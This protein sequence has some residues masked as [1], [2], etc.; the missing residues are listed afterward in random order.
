MEGTNKRVLEIF[1]VSQQG[2]YPPGRVRRN[3]NIFKDGLMYFNYTMIM[4][5]E[6]V[7]FQESLD[8]LTEKEIKDQVPNNTNYGDL[9]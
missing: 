4:T 3:R 7:E 9:E 8:N 6:G 2:F 5:T 1:W